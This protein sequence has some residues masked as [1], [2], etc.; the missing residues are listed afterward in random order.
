MLSFILRRLV[1][2][3]ITL[4]V[5]ITLTFILMHSLPG[6]PFAAGDKLSDSARAV[7]MARYGLDQP[8]YMQYLTY[9]TNLTQF[10]MGVS[11]FYPTR[12][13][14]DI[15]TQNFPVSAELGAYALLLAITVGLTL[16]TVAALNHNG[17]MDFTAMFT[18]IVGVSVPSMVL[19]PLLAYFF[20]V[21]LGWFP[22]ALWNGWEYKILPS[23]TLS[24][25]TIAVMARMMRT[26]M[27]DVIGQDYIKTAK[28][29]GL[30]KMAIVFK[31]TIRNALLPIITIA[32]P[33]IV[34][35]L[36]GTF[37]VETV[38]AV[39]GL[40]KHFITSIQTND[41]T[42]IM[43]MTIFYS[44]LLIAAIV[45]TDILYGVVD[46]RIRLAKGGK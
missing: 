13:V 42:I 31:H 25:G 27:L 17:P 37:I 11:Y 29:K 15:I 26:S 1:Y 34:N 44:A 10:D 18:A 21:K 5:I 24:F 41:Y 33:L 6:D 20:G 4:W 43:G 46:P 16:G 7:L 39:P 14:N 8:I 36:T 45:V 9:L 12:E 2:G 38:F 23:I 30:S 32:G 19:G 3:L 35:I 22:P 28:A 40:G